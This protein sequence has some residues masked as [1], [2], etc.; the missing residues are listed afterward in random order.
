MALNIKDDETD[1]LARQLA[2]ETGESI[3]VAV[4]DAIAAQLATIRR[5]SRVVADTDLSDVIARGRSRSQIDTR[6][7]NEILGYDH[8]GLPR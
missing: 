1:R 5:R 8:R 2:E 4:R 6:S 7:E 3:T